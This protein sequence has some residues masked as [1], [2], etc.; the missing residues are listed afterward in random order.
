MAPGFPNSEGAPLNCGRNDEITNILWLLQRH[1]PKRVN[2]YY[3]LRERLIIQANIGPVLPSSWY[4]S[5]A[6]FSLETCF[7]H[8]VK[9]SGRRI[10]LT[11]NTCFNHQVSISGKKPLVSNAW[12]LGE[13]NKRWTVNSMVFR[14]K[15]YGIRYTKTYK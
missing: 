10:K 8:Q 15:H 9:I 4:M 14:N 5:N 13:W 2:I 1:N 6:R 7:S 3:F 12:L 11:V